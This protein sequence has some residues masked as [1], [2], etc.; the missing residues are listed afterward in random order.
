LLVLGE[1]RPSGVVAGC[2]TANTKPLSG[3]NTEAMQLH[4]DEIATKITPGALTLF[5]SSIKPSGMAPNPQGSKKYL[6]L[7][8]PATRT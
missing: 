1:A 7:A 8:A 4:L 5:S 6:A 2:D 3:C